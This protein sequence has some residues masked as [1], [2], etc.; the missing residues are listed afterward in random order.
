MLLTSQD[1]S[2]RQ[3]FKRTQQVREQASWSWTIADGIEA[4]DS[5]APSQER[6]SVLHTD[7]S[8]GRQTE[9]GSWQ[10][11]IAQRLRHA[12]KRAALSV[13]AQFALHELRI[14]SQSACAR[15]G[16]TKTAPTRVISPAKARS[17]SRMRPIYARAT[18]AAQLLGVTSPPLI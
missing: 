4:S 7:S 15:P 3:A 12:L 5:Q 17:T 13:R 6:N 8:V 14:W 11:M 10:N 2:C 1:R 16:A 18:P 9:G